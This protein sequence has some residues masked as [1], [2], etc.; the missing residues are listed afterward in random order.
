[1]R[2]S[3]DS[4][5]SE[6]AVIPLRD[7]LAMVIINGIISGDWNFPTEFNGKEGTEAWDEQAA[8]RAYKI[9][10]AMLRTREA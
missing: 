9:A 5:F 2:V 10:D 3:L 7:R 6:G 4:L 1:M 8:L